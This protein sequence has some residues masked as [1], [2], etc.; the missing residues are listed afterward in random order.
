MNWKVILLLLAIT[1]GIGTYL[2][3]QDEPEVARNDGRPDL[4]HILPYSPDEVTRVT[5]VYFDTTYV[6]VRDGSEWDM[7]E[8]PFKAGADSLVVNHLLRV[9]CETP[10][11]TSIPTDSLDLASVDLSHPILVFTAYNEAGDSTRLEFG[12][13]NPT[14]ESIYIHRRGEGRVI[15]ANKL[16]GPMLTVNRFLLLG[17]SLTGV[18]PYNTA[19]AEVFSGGR[20]V[21]DTFRN[22]V[23][24]RWWI[25]TGRDTLWADQHQ[26]EARLAEF[27]RGQ[28]REFHSADEV[29][30]SE[31][32]L[33]NPVRVLKVTPGNGDPTVVAFGKTKND[34]DYLRWASSTLYPDQVVLV[35]S[36][37]IERLDMFC[38]DT[39]ACRELADFFP[40]DVDFISV[41]S[42]VDSVVLV[43]DN[44]TLWRIITPQEAKAKLLTVDNLLQHA[45]TVEARKIIPPG[46]DRGYETPQVRLVLKHGDDLLADLVFGNYEGEEVYARDNK[47]DM[48]FLVHSYEIAPLN[49]T[50]KYM[51]DIPV[52]HVVE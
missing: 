36:W 10:F 12:T 3:L 45:D 8:P 18:D 37:L 41:S 17:K 15:L 25:D 49:L 23:P 28:V 38:A 26:L 4:E 20:K 35:D 47:R 44:D 51:A 30:E 27:Y 22:E 33:R 31:T 9:L 1:V 14:T 46:R 50:F 42:P 52:R 21:F 2:Y 24:G 6:I 19:R 11:A 43:A 29:P 16:L 5:V 40:P 39:M 7:Q 34:M 13:L 32:G 48:D